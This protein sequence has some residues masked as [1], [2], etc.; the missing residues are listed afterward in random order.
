M[1]VPF[2]LSIPVENAIDVN[3]IFYINS[4]HTAVVREHAANLCKI[5]PRIKLG[6][7]GSLCTPPKRSINVL[8]CCSWGRMSRDC[9][10]VRWEEVISY[11]VV[12]LR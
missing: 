11:D 7:N 8:Q 3:S 1:Y 12:G 4:E 6:Q 5:Y 2:G 10:I 9:G